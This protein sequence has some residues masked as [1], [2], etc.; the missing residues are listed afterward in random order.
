MIVGHKP[1][2]HVVFYDAKGNKIERETRQC[3]HCQK[4]WIYQP[5]SKRK[6]GF[7]LKCY[8][9]ICAECAMKECNG[10]FEK[11]LERK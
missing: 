1:A 4:T 8:G 2:G 7:C 10:P 6:Y 5:G 3:V 9:I 11:Q